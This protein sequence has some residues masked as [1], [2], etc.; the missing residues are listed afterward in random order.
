MDEDLRVIEDPEKA[1]KVDL[2]YIFE[3]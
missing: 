1:L 3:D 2:E